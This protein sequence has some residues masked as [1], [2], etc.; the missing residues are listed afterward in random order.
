VL[1]PTVTP[2]VPVR[3]DYELTPLGISLL[4]PIRHLKSWAE[5]HMADVDSARELRPNPFLT[6]HQPCLR[7]HLAAMDSS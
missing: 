2:S 4:E 7:H 3:V 6:A 5:A 1:T